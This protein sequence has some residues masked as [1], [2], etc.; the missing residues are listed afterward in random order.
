[1]AG[2]SDH[3]NDQ[4]R[5]ME[6]PCLDE[7]HELLESGPDKGGD[8]EVRVVP[9]AA[10]KQPAPKPQELPRRVRIITAT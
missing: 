7:S 4:V 1:M 5:S 3:S 9:K 6:L 8:E 10:I 2:S